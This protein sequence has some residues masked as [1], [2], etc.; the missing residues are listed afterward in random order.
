MARG[1][2]VW[3]S[4]D[5]KE[6]GQFIRSDQMRDVTAEVAEDMAARMRAEAPRSRGPG[7]HMA[8]QFKVKKAAGFGK[9]SGNVR[10]KVEI[11]NSDIA[12]AANEYGLRNTPR[13]RTM[14]R[15]AGKFGDFK[16]HGDKAGA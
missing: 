1:R 8:D 13:R 5:H 12:A 9:V 16:L 6:F 10:V 3:Y 15:V 7:P 4:P 11:F 2:Y 14:A